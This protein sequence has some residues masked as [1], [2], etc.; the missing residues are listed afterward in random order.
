[1]EVKFHPNFPQ[2]EKKKKNYDIQIARVSREGARDTAELELEAKWEL[3]FRYKEKSAFLAPF[4]LLRC[5][6][7]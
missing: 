1:M 4:R 7:L 6:K 3:T 5:I 2:N